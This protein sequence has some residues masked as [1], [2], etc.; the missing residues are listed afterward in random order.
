MVSATAD[1]QHANSEPTVA[2]GNMPLNRTEENRTKEKKESATDAAGSLPEKTS[3]TKRTA[4][5]HPQFPPVLEALITAWNELPAGIAPRCTKRSSAIVS[6]FKR[7]NGQPEVAAA[8][9]DVAKVMAAIR[10]GSFLHGQN[11]FKF[12]WLFGKDRAGEWNACKIIEGNYRDRSNSNRPS[13]AKWQGDSNDFAH[14]TVPAAASAAGSAGGQ[15]ES[16]AG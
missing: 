12:S 1:Q 16:R 2:L 14:L 3:K 15:L 7:A 10:E 6:A 13:P 11:W 5:T 4:K 9:S 8:L